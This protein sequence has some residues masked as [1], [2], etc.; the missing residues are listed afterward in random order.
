M[1]SCKCEKRYVGETKLKISTRIKQHEE[2]IKYKKWDSS[3]VFFHAKI[4]KEG[5]NWENTSTLKIEDRR[6]DHKVRETL[7]I[8]SGRRRHVM[9]MVLTKMM[10]SM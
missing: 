8:H 9:N 2:T 3:G 5:F 6:F 1:V 10:A 7:E 4:C